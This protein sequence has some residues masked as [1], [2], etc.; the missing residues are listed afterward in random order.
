MSVS[1]ATRYAAVVVRARELGEQ[2]TS[3][4]RPFDN[5]YAARKVLIDLRDDLRRIRAD[6]PV[7]DAIAALEYRCGANYIECE[8]HHGGW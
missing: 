1:I 3:E 4:S 8:E 7:L 5:K 6:A 2:A